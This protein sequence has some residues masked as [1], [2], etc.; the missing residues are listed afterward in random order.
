MTLLNVDAAVPSQTW[1]LVRLLLSLKKNVPLDDAEAFLCPPSLVP[2]NKSSSAFRSALS[3]LRNLGLVH[4]DQARNQLSLAGRATSLDSC[5]DLAAYTTVLRHAV[6]DADLNTDLGVDDSFVG[7]RDLTRALAW[8]LMHDPAEPAIDG[9]EAV[10]LIDA[11][12]GKDRSSLKPEVLPLFPNSTRWNRLNHWAPFLGLA[13]PSVIRRDGSGSMVP[14][15]TTAVRQTVFELWH[16]G[17]RVNAVEALRALR[18]ALPVLPGGA[19]SLAIGIASPGEDVAGPALSFALLRGDDEGWLRLEHDDDAP[20]PLLIDDADRPASRRTVSN[21][22][23][24]EAA[25]G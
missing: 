3:T 1:A 9:A 8:F 25:H 6:F 19:H 21:I 4:V 7:P 17:H 24:L 13:T 5:D 23:I 11:E 2:A 16:V 10:R 20:R 14:D 18:S 15:C 12:D 22:T